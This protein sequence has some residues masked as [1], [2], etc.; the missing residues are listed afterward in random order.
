MPSMIA[1]A[2]SEGVNIYCPIDGRFSFFNSPYFA[3]R[4][5]TGIDIYPGS[6]S[7]FEGDAPS[8]VSG[9]V[10]FIK[11]V[12]YFENRGFEHSKVDYL[13]ILRSIENKGRLIKILH[14]KPS[15]NIGDRV[16]V[17]ERIGTLIRSGFFDFWTDPHIHVE[18]RKPSDPIRARGGYR[19]RRVIRISEG[20]REMLSLDWIRGVVIEVKHEYSLISPDGD[21]KHGIPVSLGDGVGLIDGGIPHYGFFGVHADFTPKL[22]ER[23]KLLGKTI[24]SIRSISDGMHLADSSNVT[25]RLNGKPVRLSLYLFPSK[26]IIKVIPQKPGDISLERFEEVKL[27]VGE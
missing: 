25:F 22:G 8:P 4:N 21:F 15:V 12:N 11:E 16:M 10:M 6:N 23:V 17:G 9:K 13:I 19:I 7:K 5:F 20:C 26:P 3:H 14:V 2:Y 24:G 18:V 1:A 27:S